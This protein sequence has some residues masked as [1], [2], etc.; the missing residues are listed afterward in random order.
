MRE[1]SFIQ[2]EF[3][4]A[5]RETVRRAARW[6]DDNTFIALGLVSLFTFATVYALVAVLK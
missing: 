3:R 2:M 5:A 1:R 6:Y 4:N